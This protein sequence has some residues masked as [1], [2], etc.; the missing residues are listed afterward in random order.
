MEKSVIESESMTGLL[1]LTTSGLLDLFGEGAAA[2]VFF[3]A[4][5]AVSFN[6][7]CCN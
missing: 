5:I 7:S 4:K 6:C 3:W 2:G 1:H